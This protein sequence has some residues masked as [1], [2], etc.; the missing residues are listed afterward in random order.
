MKHLKLFESF[1]RYEFGIFDDKNLIY[2]K[3]DE[4]E[5]NSIDLTEDEIETFASVLSKRKLAHNHTYVEVFQEDGD[6]YRI[7]SLGDFCYAIAH[8]YHYTDF[9]TY[10]ET[11]RVYKIWVVDQL[12]ELIPYL[13]DINKLR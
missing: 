9:N 13:E 6:S 8:I 4:I 11:Y 3:Y 2:G 12:D 7:F 10:T 5:N 1:D